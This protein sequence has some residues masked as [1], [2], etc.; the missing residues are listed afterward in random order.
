MSGEMLKRIRGAVGER[1]A[2]GVRLAPELVE[3]VGKGGG[4]GGVDAGTAA[5]TVYVGRGGFCEVIERIGRAGGADVRRHSMGGRGKSGISAAV[6]AERRS[7]AGV[8]G[9]PERRGDGGGPGGPVFEGA[10]RNQA[11]GP[12]GGGPAGGWR[13]S[14]DRGLDVG[15][16]PRGRGERGIGARGGKPVVRGGVGARLGGESS[17]RARAMG[18]EVLDAVKL[19]EMR[20]SDN[21]VQTIVGRLERLNEG[22]RKVLTLCAVMGRL[23]EFRDVAGAVGLREGLGGAGG[24]A[25]GGGRVEGGGGRAAGGADSGGVWVYA[26]QDSRGDLRKVDRNRA[27][28]SDGLVAKAMERKGPGR[29]TGLRAGE[30]LREIQRGRAGGALRDARGGNGGGAERPSGSPGLFRAGGVAFGADGGQRGSAGSAGE[31]LGEGMGD[32]GRMV[33]QYSDTVF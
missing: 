11:G 3:V 30:P 24:G 17:D 9:V 26:R 13:Y 14:Q 21:L 18:W 20:Y 4:G 23:F 19:K 29:G 25:T 33:G 1:A 5:G 6:R 7:G 15:G 10:G 2:D 31:G 8:V 16:R 12:G 27:G 22:E 32:S 28:G